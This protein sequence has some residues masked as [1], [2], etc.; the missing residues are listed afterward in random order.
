MYQTKQ[1]KIAIFLVLALLVS[2]LPLIPVLAASTYPVYLRNDQGWTDVRIFYSGQKEDLAEVEWPGIPMT[3]ENA[4]DNGYEIYSVEVPVSAGMIVFTGRNAEGQLCQSADIKDIQFDSCYCLNAD[5]SYTTYVFEERM[6]EGHLTSSNGSY[7]EY[8]AVEV[9]PPTCTESGYTIYECIYCGSTQWDN[10][11]DELGHTPVEGSYR[12]VAPTCT[13]D[14]GEFYTCVTCSEEYCDSVESATGHTPKEGADTVTPPTCTEPGGATSV[15]ETCGASYITEETAA[16][17]HT[18]GDDDYCDVCGVLPLT[19]EMKDDY[20]DGWNG[21]GIAVYANGNLLEVATIDSGSSASF[22]VSYDAAKTYTFYWVSGAYAGECSFVLKLGQTELLSVDGNGCYNYEDNAL[23]YTVESKCSHEFDSGVVKAP[24]CTE[25]GCTAYTCGLCGFVRK[26]NLIEATGHNYVGGICTKCGNITPIQIVMRDAYSDSWNNAAIIV[27]TTAGET[28]V[29][30]DNS[31]SEQTVTLD[32]NPAL[33]YE[34]YWQQG[35]YDSECSFTVCLGDEVLFEIS[36]NED[37]VL[38]DEEL[39]CTIEIPCEHNFVYREVAPT[40][41]EEGYKGDVCTI[42]GKVDAKQYIKPNSH[43]F[44]AKTVVAP[45]CEE[46]GYTATTCTVCGHV[47]KTNFVKPVPHTYGENDRCTDCQARKLLTIEMQSE[48]TGWY[49]PTALRVYVDDVLQNDVAIRY[50]HESTWSMTYDSTKSYV[51]RWSEGYSDYECAFRILLGDEVVYIS[52]PNCDDYTQDQIIYA[53][54]PNCTHAAMTEEVIA[55]RCDVEGYTRHYCTTCGYSY[56][57]TY[58]D[59]TGHTYDSYNCCEVCGEPKPTE[60]PVLT[61][62]DISLTFE[63]EILMNVYFSATN[64]ADVVEYGLATYGYLVDDPAEAEPMDV[65]YGY[66][67][68]EDKYGVTTWGIPA[69]EMGDTVYFSVFA[70]LRDGTYVYSKVYY[71]APTSYA[72]SMLNKSATPQEMKSLIVAMLNYGAAAQ[73]YFGY[74]TDKMVNANLT[75]EQ[76]AFV[77]DYNGEMLDGLTVCAAEKKGELFGNGNTGFGKRTP[78][79]NFEG[80]FSVNFYF[81]QPKATVGSDVTFYIWDKAAYDSAETLLP[82]NATTTSTCIFDGTYYAGIVEG[83]AAK[84]VDETFYCAAVFTGTDGNTYV[85]GV[86]AYS[87]GYYLENQANGTKM[88][89]FAKATGVYAYYA[90]TLF[91]A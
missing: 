44:G 24:N 4:K 56:M 45:T 49:E 16:L 11:V 31:I 54:V 71:Y 27:K 74:K 68:S 23:I 34:F 26:D 75:A 82:E 10:Y 3:K 18:L 90:K 8:E 51:I 59:A 39:F 40:C 52:N 53:V 46:D 50:S 62:S 91:N 69:K 58:V 47:R 81:G 80:A 41:T 12:Y 55:P 6:L 5:G 66:T 1:R 48:Y 88:P 86:I 9:V 70:Y 28:T 60:V 83:I 20:S 15:C 14:G 64:T 35:N 13:E 37:F 29:T 38:R 84:Q 73:E 25:D 79:V 22:S 2:L 30:M 85:S 72:Y 43:S 77:A 61:P 63:D 32:Y 19:V 57:D 89:D 65:R 42:C 78:S 17:G 7:C 67:T 33:K 21:N 36:Q 76:K 87:L